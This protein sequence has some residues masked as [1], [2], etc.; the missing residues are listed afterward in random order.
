MATTESKNMSTALTQET[1]KLL[2]GLGSKLASQAEQSLFTKATADL[3]QT[4]SSP[5]KSETTEGFP[6]EP[7]PEPEPVPEPEPELDQTENVDS[8]APKPQSGPPK[9]MSSIVKKVIS[10]KKPEGDPPP[11]KA[12]P[13][14]TKEELYRFIDL[15]LG[16]G[17]DGTNAT[18]WLNKTSFQVR[19]VAFDNIV[20]TEEGGTWQSY[21]REV[22]SIQTHQAQIKGS[23]VV[24][25]SPL[26]IG[27]D[28]EVSRSVS[29]LRRTVGKIVK[30]RTI[31]FR[32]DFEDI[33]TSK[34]KV[35]AGTFESRL[36]KWI[37]E[38]H[39]N[40]I[41]NF[42]SLVSFMEGDS[43]DAKSIIE[44]ACK[45]VVEFFCIT[46][47]V[48]AIELGAAEYRVLQEE[49]YHKAISSSGSLGIEKIANVVSKYSYSSKKKKKASDVKSIGRIGP[50]HTVERGSLGE[51]VV[52]VKIQPI[53]NL[54]RIQC[55]REALNA[56]LV[57]FVENQS[58]RSGKR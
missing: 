3:L 31:S 57:Q 33:P 26:T 38:T 39:K 41:G 34:E 24:P 56:A 14:H 42:E 19:P 21:E 16:R 50:D 48:S 36:I 27:A 13:V 44:V 15:G 45:E 12:D 4:I 54:V 18:P 10:K 6:G 2:S 43:A 1:S 47:Y 49:E 9:T 8:D 5:D 32:D 35:I 52:G 7:E 55:L 20:G 40:K 53:A 46:H 23:L 25:Q 28:A 51:A 37:M 17:L 58:N 22:L 29:T 30:N 11:K